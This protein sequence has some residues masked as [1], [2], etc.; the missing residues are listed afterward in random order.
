MECGQQ[1][2][3]GTRQE[4]GKRKT[5]GLAS[6]QYRVVGGG[7]EHSRIEKSS[8]QANEELGRRGSNG[9]S[10]SIV[11]DVASGAV[12]RL[13]ERRLAASPRNDCSTPIEPKQYQNETRTHTK[14]STRDNLS[15]WLL[16]AFPVA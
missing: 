3:C 1:K 10:A 15:C 12:R 11:T 4:T 8:R 7:G 13:P 5:S 6:Q 16:C 9:P 14:A 2:K